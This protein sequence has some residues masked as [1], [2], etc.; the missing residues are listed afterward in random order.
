M[1]DKACVIDIKAVD[2]KYKIKKSKK[3]G[4][5]KRPL[6]ED[7][8]ALKNINLKIRQG[9]RVGIIGK[10]GAGKSTLL[11]LLARITEP[12]SGRIEIGGKLSAMLEVGTGFNA[13]LTG[14]E[15]V[16]LNGAILGMKKSEI[17]R[18]FDQI[19][20]FSEI[21]PF[22]DMPVKRYSSGMYVRLAF[23]VASHLEPDILILD[24]V[25][26]VGDQKFRQKCLDRINE[27][28]QG[29][30]TILCVSHQMDLIRELCDRVIVLDRGKIVYDGDTES[31]IEF[32]GKNQTQNSKAFF[33]L[34][35]AARP[36]FLR[37]KALMESLEIKNRNEFMGG[38]DNILS[39]EI[40]LKALEDLADV[41]LRLMV[42]Y[43][44]DTKAGFAQLSRGL[45]IKEGQTVKQNLTFDTSSLFPGKY[46]AGLALF[47]SDSTGKAEHFD[48][49]REAFSFEI[50]ED[51]QAD[52]SIS[53]SHRDWGHV[54]LG[55]LESR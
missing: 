44:D 20:D 32:Y 1:T 35:E 18:K 7:F 28:L 34:T 41:K 11:K 46:I 49:I 5:F 33:D 14:R 40:S 16:Y 30:K 52:K 27:I 9:E 12:S 23:A 25:F 8:Y 39:F 31:A 15:N 55:E 13:E 10:N 19:A 6:Y 3:K 22:I 26:A 38:K 51:G 36:S 53:Y 43:Y 54:F 4:P 37:Q 45:N 29:D 50:P 2:K 47:S 21:G 17:D 48:Y 42:R 24:E